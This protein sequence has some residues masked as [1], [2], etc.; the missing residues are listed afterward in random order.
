M[1][2]SLRFILPLIFVLTAIAY[3]T[4]PLADKF[5]FRWFSR[6]LDMRA[7]LIASTLS[8]SLAATQRI[9]RQRERNK[10]LTELFSHATQDERLFAL[11]YCNPQAQIEVKT[12]RFPDSLSCAPQYQTPHSENI[13]LRSGPLHV[14]YQP[15]PA[16]GAQLIL[17][18]DLSFIK[19]RSNDTKRYLFFFFVI[20]TLV[21]SF[22]TVAIARISWLGWIRGLKSILKMDQTER[23]SVRGISP[24]LRPVA[25][26]IRRFVRELESERGFQDESQIS[27]SAQTLRDVLKHDLAGEEVLIVSNREPYI[28]VHKN[29]KIDIQSPASGL[30]TAL[31]PIMRA[32]SGTW[33]AHGS[34]SADRTVVDANNKVQVPPKKPAYNLKRVWLTSEEEK[35]YY[36]GFA[37]EGLWPLCHIAH[38]RPIFRS[39]DW[40]QYL[41]VN[42]KF[43][44]AVAEES[45]T[46]DPVILVQDYHFAMLPRMI[47]Q[48]LPEA[49]V[50]SFWH[51]PWPNAESFGICP[52]REKILE[53][54]LGSD[55]LG[56]HT[57]VHCNNFIEAVDRYLESRIDR[58]SSTIFH[59]DHRTAIRSYPISID[60]PMRGLEEQMPTA[61]CRKLVVEENQIPADAYIGIGVDRL[62][63]TK[64]ILERMYA[65]ERLLEMDPSLIGKLVFIQI[66]A[67]TRTSLA[68]YR[69]FE[70]HLRKESDRI[71]E[72]FSRGQ[73]KPLIMRLQHHEAPDVIRYFRASDFCFVSSLHDGMNLVAKEFIASRDDEQGVLI[74]SQFTGA[75]RE[76]PEAL[77]VNPYDI[78]QCALAVK[79]AMEMD[80]NERKA[81]MRNMR[82]FIQEYNV[83]RWAGRMLLDA[84]RLRRRGRFANPVLNS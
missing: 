84:A 2:L 60:W 25:K 38:T 55:I 41:A 10:K 70:E 73:Y 44:Q 35:G 4:I 40:N 28:H 71:N 24:E 6:D 12:A 77:I 14:S 81:R 74:L 20:L 63:Y 58:D 49:T 51:I 57:R 9:D 30:V 52:W 72:R 17:V 69:N 8:D 76:L 62:D 16:L 59:G 13:E 82:A 75:A 80:P 61:D 66:G 79:H 36:Y 37:N 11:G 22:L 50:I 1:G 68:E 53:G 27:W 29:D 31:E 45:K 7:E 21:V 5:T 67:P 34:G 19:T 3:V 23:P 64:G 33:I 83:Y 32:C 65:I 26:D 54:M 43:A 18:H 56:F 39:E 78:D 48:R 15:V 46:K 42:E 47:K